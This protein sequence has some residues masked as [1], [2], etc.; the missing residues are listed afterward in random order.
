MPPKNP[1]QATH[2]FARTA[3]VFLLPMGLVFLL[4]TLALADQVHG[5]LRFSELGRLF[6]LNVVLGVGF[7]SSGL[8]MAFVAFYY[9]KA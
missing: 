4:N 7:T 6:L 3:A 8:M 1:H 9:R 2:Q 5:D